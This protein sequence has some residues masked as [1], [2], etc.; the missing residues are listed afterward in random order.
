MMCDVMIY[1]PLLISHDYQLAPVGICQCLFE[2]LMASCRN[3]PIPQ[4][5]LIPYQAVA[6]LLSGR[7]MGCACIKS[8]TAPTTARLIVE[9]EPVYFDHIR[10]ALIRELV[11]IWLV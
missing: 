8:R 9:L 5:P 7:M 4:M 3:I 2:Q 6:A 1:E 10:T 11:I